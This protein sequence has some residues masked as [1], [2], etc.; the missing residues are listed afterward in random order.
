[1][2]E[3]IVKLGDS[4]VQKNI[5]VKETIRI[6]RVPDNEIVIENLAVSRYHAVI[7]YVDGNYVLSDLDSSNGIFVNGVRVRKT[8]LQDRD[9]ISIGK[10]KLYFYDARA[11]AEPKPRISALDAERTML[12]DQQPAPPPQ[13]ALEIIKG[14]Q[15]GAR[16]PLSANQTT[17]GSGA[18]ND[19]QLTDWFISKAH[20]VIER[21][22]GDFVI[23]DLGSWRH[24]YVNGVMATELPLSDGDIIQLGPSVQIAFSMARQD[25]PLTGQARVPVELE[26]A[27]A[28]GPGEAGPA[29]RRHD[30]D[31]PIT[32]RS[33]RPVVRGWME[34]PFPAAPQESAPAPDVS[35][36][37]DPLDILAAAPARG[38]MDSLYATPEP[39]PEPF[40]RADEAA[41][42]AP[43]APFEADPT[44]QEPED[45][46][47]AERPTP[48]Q[49]AAWDQASALD[50]AP[51]PDESPAQD[52][53]PAP[54][55][56][57]PFF[58]A[59]E[60]QAEVAAEPAM[61]ET[62]EFSEFPES[63]EPAEEAPAMQETPDY[64]FAA[65]A[66]PACPPQDPSPAAAAEPSCDAESA[67]SAEPA[68]EEP[69]RPAEPEQSPAASSIDLEQEIQMWERALQN[70]NLIIRKQAAR[71]LQ[72]L[73]GKQYDYS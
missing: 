14:R 21:R 11:A 41:S 9:V 65:P 50:Q 19:I 70:K 63:P 1:M 2:P 37:N 24:T 10:H 39:P 69:V 46:E 27:F 13:G 44:W 7:E 57:H 66:E 56:M 61:P 42:N 60:A 64:D 72:K 4:I 28:N 48:D 12:F 59:A 35:N 20:A 52:E 31:E 47:V 30:D 6:G 43:A 36:S 5:F 71:Q 16:I 29:V 55:E 53:A 8:E 49:A 34:S 58:F 17:L 25:L 45:E 26:P 73:T 23:R 40:W 54:A 15:K 18:F 3:L 32:S 68:Q 62:Q 38:A 51:A 22:P 33:L 67:A